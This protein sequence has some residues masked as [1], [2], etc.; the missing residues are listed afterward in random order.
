VVANESIMLFAAKTLVLPT[1]ML[2][3]KVAAGLLSLVA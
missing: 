1:Q 3:N 2:R